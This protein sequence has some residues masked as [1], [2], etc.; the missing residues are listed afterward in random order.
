MRAA[1]YT[2]Q[3]ARKMP[4]LINVPDRPVTL[5]TDLDALCADKFDSKYDQL[6][7]WIRALICQLT[8]G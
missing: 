4:G 1:L 3:N 7:K 8:S 6:I 2:S 5:G